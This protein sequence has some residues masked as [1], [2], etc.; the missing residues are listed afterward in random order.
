MSTEK[1]IIGIGNALMDVVTKIPNDEIFANYDFPKGSMTLVDAELSAK[2]NK[3]TEDCEKIYA[4][5]GSVAN[6]IDGI[7]HLGGDAAFI[8]KVG[9]DDLGKQYGDGLKS[10]GATPKLFESESTGTGVASALVTPDGERTFGTYLGAAIELSAADITINLF[11]GYDIAYIEG[12]LV[13]NHDLIRK[14]CEMAQK[15]GLSIAIDLSSFNVVEDNLDFL[16]E[17]IEKYIDIIFANEEEAKAFT[18]QE[19]DEAIH[20]FA[21]LCDIAVVKVGSKGSLIKSGE[22][23]ETAGTLGTPC[24]DSTG[25]G[26]LYAAGFLYGLSKG[27]SLKKAAEI[28]AITAGNVITVYGARMDEAM[29]SDINKKVAEI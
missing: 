18:G 22:I 10:V 16:K 7:A 28:G 20:T 9:K 11:D 27:M 23:Y 29:W 1:R 19:P 3:D 13:Q 2:I 12:Y 4:P 6:T 25:A 26:D 21:D 14:A 15:S 8:G 17:I 5:G 24:N